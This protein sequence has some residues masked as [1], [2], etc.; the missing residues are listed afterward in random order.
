MCLCVSNCVKLP[1][2]C[3]PNERHHKTFAFTVSSEVQALWQAQAARWFLVLSTALE[4]LR[5]LASKNSLCYK[6][7][8]R[9]HTFLVVVILEMVS[10]KQTRNTFK[11]Y[12]YVI[13]RHYT[14]Y[15]NT[16]SF[17]KSFYSI[18]C[19]ILRS[20]ILQNS[21]INIGKSHKGLHLNITQ[22]I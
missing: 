17:L 5:L 12:S 10:W 14:N 2:T 3:N 19:A 8:G 18:W 21:L 13:W 15:L 11:K 1:Y 7:L 9:S 22:S 6:V 16:K 4:S 20:I